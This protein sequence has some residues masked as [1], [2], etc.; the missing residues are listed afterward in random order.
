MEIVVPGG[1]YRRVKFG[2]I[3]IIQD[4]KAVPGLDKKA[5]AVSQG[6]LSGYLG[7]KVTVILTVLGHWVLAALFEHGAGDAP[8][9]VIPVH[10]GFVS[11]PLGQEPQMAAGTESLYVAVLTGEEGVFPKVQRVEGIPAMSP[12]SCKAKTGSEES[13]AD[14]GAAAGGDGP[15]CSTS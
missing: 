6:L 7:C 14:F 8:P 15:K 11:A 5:Q 3:H 13:T 12:V 9:C 4:F 2:D 10:G 1:A